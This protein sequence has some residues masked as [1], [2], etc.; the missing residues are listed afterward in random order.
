[1]CLIIYL[2]GHVISYF[3]SLVYYEAVLTIVVG[4]VVFNTIDISQ[5]E[6]KE[7]RR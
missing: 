2:V 6:I 4:L 1:M 3:T 7:K 5:L